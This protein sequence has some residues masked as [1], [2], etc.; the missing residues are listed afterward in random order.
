MTACAAAK[1]SLP[2]VIERA[3]IEVTTIVALSTET[4][5][6]RDS[7]Q[8]CCATLVGP[9]GAENAAPGSTLLPMVVRP[10]RTLTTVVDVL[11]TSVNVMRGRPCAVQVTESAP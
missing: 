1:Q 5:S 3:L 2:P 11:A 6:L 10:A 4:G 8:V 7:C 9:R